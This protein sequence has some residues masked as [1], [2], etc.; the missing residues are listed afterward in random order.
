MPHPALSETVSKYARQPL[1]HEF[2][3]FRRSADERLA[4][5][6]VFLAID[7]AFRELL[8]ENFAGRSRAPLTAPIP[9]VKPH[10]GKPETDQQRQREQH[11]NRTEAH[12]PA[13]TRPPI[14]HHL[15]VSI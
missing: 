8:I 9:V 11:E 7:L 2:R 10:N 4:P 6:L 13:S 5:H 3:V 12:T 1:A 15:A 14:M